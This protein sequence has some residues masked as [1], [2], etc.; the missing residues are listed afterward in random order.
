MAVCSRE[1]AQSASRSR[2]AGVCQET[3]LGPVLWLIRT[4]LA[5]AAHLLEMTTQRAFTLLRTTVSEILL[6]PQ[7]AVE[8]MQQLR[9]EK[10]IALH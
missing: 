3:C 5:S 2:S 7:Y 8:L 9:D 4:H 6:N 1:G 10:I